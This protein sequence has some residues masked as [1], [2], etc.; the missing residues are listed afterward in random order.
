[1]GVI[2][3]LSLFDTHTSEPLYKMVEWMNTESDNFFTEMLTKTLAAED[4][5]TAQGTTELGLNVIREFMHSTGFDT[6]SVIT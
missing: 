4:C 2:R 1:V 3:G 6:L 5:I